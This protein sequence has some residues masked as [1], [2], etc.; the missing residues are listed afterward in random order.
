VL[1]FRS[2]QGEADFQL[3]R[4]ILV[5]SNRANQIDDSLSLEAIRR[6]CAPSARFD[7]RLDILFALDQTA[8]REC[9]AIGFSRVGWYTGKAR[10]R[11]YY[12]DS[13]LHPDWRD[14]DVWP[15][16]VRQS[17]RR[18]RVIAA[19]HPLLA[20]RFF[21]G[22]AAGSQVEWISVLEGEGYQAVRH[23]DN[24]LHSLSDIPDRALPAGLELRPVRPEHYRSIWEAQRSVQQELFEFVAE[25]WTEEKYAPWAANPA[26][27]PHLWQVAWDG[28]QVAGMVL[29]RIDEAA[30]KELSRRRGYTEHIFVG[31]AWRKR[32]LASALLASSLRILK[33]QGMDEAE[34]GVDRE[35]ESGA[36]AFYKT[37]GYQTYST[38]IW[39]RKPIQ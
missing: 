36:Y 8:S 31:Q 18:L 24:M 9:R 38:D 14:R 30:N 10:V 28:H 12:Q 22:W 25:N 15:G 20:E 34:L 1:T 11:L 32:G 3:M 19:G 4:S 26:H 16:L 17:E 2:F 39:Y 7:P 29:T 37:M 5:E 35:N 13:Y 27:T 33:E 21:Q 23:F 6:W